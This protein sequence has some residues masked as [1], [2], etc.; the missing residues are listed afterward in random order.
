MSRGLEATTLCLYLFEIMFR[1]GKI[2]YQLPKKYMNY[3]S[4]ILTL[5]NNTIKI[6]NDFIIAQIH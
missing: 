4:R 6:K 2:I 3:T 1:I 5:K